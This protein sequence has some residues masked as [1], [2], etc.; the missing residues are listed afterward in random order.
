MAP[1][2]FF[3][4]RDAAAAKG[5]VSSLRTARQRVNHEAGLRDPRLPISG[6]SRQRGERVQP[7][8]LRAPLLLVFGLLQPP[9][10]A[11]RRFRSIASEMVASRCCNARFASCER[12]T[13]SVRIAS[14]SKAAYLAL[15]ASSALSRSSCCCC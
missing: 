5:F 9:V 10:V 14:A 15:R 3:T 2:T 8:D 4:G 12:S 7:P 13:A 6:W 11:S 1:L